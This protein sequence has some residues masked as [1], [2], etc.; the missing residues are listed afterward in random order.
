MDVN[1]VTD[2]DCFK[3]FCLQL[4]LYFD[5][6]ATFHNWSHLKIARGEKER[7][8]VLSACERAKHTSSCNQLVWDQWR[9]DKVFDF[10]F[11][12]WCYVWSPML[13]FISRCS[14]H[15]TMATLAMLWLQRRGINTTHG[16]GSWN[17]HGL[18]P[19]TQCEIFAGMHARPL[20]PTLLY[21][22]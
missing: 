6:C 16:E 15:L 22:S 5:A 13:G 2:F 10:D 19:P 14:P 20:I 11:D 8:H 12:G 4:R 18:S 3:A 7:R 1:S 9:T 21:Y 17:Q